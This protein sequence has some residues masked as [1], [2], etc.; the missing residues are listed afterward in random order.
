[1]VDALTDTAFAQLAELGE[2]LERTTK[3]RELAALLADF[4]C[5]LSPNEIPAAVRLTIGQ[6]FP[7]W[8]GRSL[9]VSWK[10]VMAAVDE[11]VDAPDDVQDEVSV[12]AVDGG[13]AYICYWSGLAA[14]HPARRR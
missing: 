11:L 1:M 7:E 5:D 4:L 9:N 8:D 14:N 2:Q 10:A 13:E 12:Q 3:R 6:V